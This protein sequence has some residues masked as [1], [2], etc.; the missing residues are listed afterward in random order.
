M[1]GYRRWRGSASREYFVNSR[2]YALIG[3]A[4]F[5]SAPLPGF[6]NAHAQHVTLPPVSVDEPTQKPKRAK[7]AASSDRQAAASRQN[8]QNR[9]AVRA[10]PT[11]SERAA[12]AAAKLN[13]AKLGY[14]AMPSATT[15]RTSA[16]PLDTS[17]TVNV[18]PEQVLKDQLPRNL[19]DALSNVSGVTQGNTLA[20]SF[21]SVMRRGFGDNRDGSIMRNGMPLV[22]GR[23]LNAAVESVEVLK[24]PAS[25]LYGI[26]DPGGIVKTISKRPDLYQHGSITLLGSTYAN[27]KNGADGTIDI[28]GPIGT[29][30]VAYRFIGYGVN[31][32]Y[33][34]NFGERK[35]SLIAPSLAW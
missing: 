27:N 6:Q 2:A 5:V 13:E 10:E 35:E 20:G 17:Q 15:L 34:R 26:Q 19:D 33:W 23:S 28:T 18:V 1:R 16:S 25:L 3:A 7:P 9:N 14:R 29:N 12:A 32:D 31:E 30:G 8:R 24:G 11:P 4:I 21:D 22:Q